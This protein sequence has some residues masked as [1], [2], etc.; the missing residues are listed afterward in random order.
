MAARVPTAA[1]MLRAIP[2]F[3]RGVDLLY[4]TAPPFSDHI[5]GLML[6]KLTGV[7]WVMEMRDPWTDNAHRTG[8]RYVAAAEALERWLERRCL[9][10]ADF[11]VAAA[12]GTYQSM[13]QKVG[14]GLRDHL[15]L[16]LNGIDEIVPRATSRPRTGPLRVVHAGS[17]YHDPRPFLGAL[18]AVCRR[19]GLTSQDIEV[20]FIGR[21]LNRFTDPTPSEL[22]ERLALGDI[23]RFTPW[24]P[25]AEATTRVQAADL[26]L[27]LC[28]D[29]PTVIPNKLFD[30][31][32]ARRPILAFVDRGGE[33]ER[34]LREAGPH[35][36]ANNA[37]PAAA[38]A[39]LEAVLDSDP[40][41][42]FPVNEERLQEWSTAQQMGALI[43]RL[44]ASLASPSPRDR[45]PGAE[46]LA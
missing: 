26:L 14:E 20:E 5:A 36:L 27:L 2:V 33:A 42:V 37:E 18:A 12:Q 35:Y 4:T 34:M 44:E 23:V 45:L 10:S 17:L 21:N 22:I 15:I 25:R 8:N 39:A 28:E 1:A 46:R 31:L 40:D 29:F 43:S 16:T 32:G 6:K 9:R 30:Y 41:D 3:R 19:R 7:P 38:E 13:E 24:L 11:V